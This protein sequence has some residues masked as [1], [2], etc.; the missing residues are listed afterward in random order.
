MNPCRLV[1][2][3]DTNFAVSTSSSLSYTLHFEVD[4]RSKHLSLHFDEPKNPW[5]SYLKNKLLLSSLSSSM[6]FRALSV[7]NSA[8]FMPT[9]HFSFLNL[10]IELFITS[11]LFILI[12]RVAFNIQC[13][14][15]FMVYQ[16]T[17]AMLLPQ[18]KIYPNG[19]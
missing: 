1:N 4:E 3:Q 9:S 6:C 11:P 2:L 19:K 5:K 16:L 18:I 10:K 12:K 7:Y 14:F 13:S 15:A 17:N 8:H